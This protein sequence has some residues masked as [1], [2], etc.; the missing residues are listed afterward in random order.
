MNS[1]D[2]FRTAPHEPSSGSLERTA[3]TEDDPVEKSLLHLIQERA[4]RKSADDETGA[5]PESDRSSWETTES[6]DQT[7]DFMA[8][9]LG[10]N[11]F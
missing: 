1:D 8:I 6:A 4:R 2:K 3:P 11:G 7:A 9:R 5:P 10:G